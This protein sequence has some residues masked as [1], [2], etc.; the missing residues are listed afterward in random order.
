MWLCQRLYCFAN[1]YKLCL[2]LQRPMLSFV[3]H[4]NHLQK[5]HAQLRIKDKN[6]AQYIRLTVD[7]GFK[8]NMYISDITKL[9]TPYWYI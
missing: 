7:I 2:I 4:C 6:K 3:N 1:T 5:Y 9:K 8:E